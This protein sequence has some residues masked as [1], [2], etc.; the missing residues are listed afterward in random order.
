M[1][2]RTLVCSGLLTM[3]FSE[4]EK[5]IKRLRREKRFIKEFP[6]K[7]WKKRTG[8]FVEE[9]ARHGYCGMEGW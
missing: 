3:E 5:L 8:L 2:S 7:Y 9:I 4:E 1:T 6:D